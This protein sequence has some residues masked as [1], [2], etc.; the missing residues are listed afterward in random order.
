VRT[1][2][3]MSAQPPHELG[4]GAPLRGGSWP[5]TGAGE[6]RTTPRGRRRLLI[7]LIAGAVLIFL[8]VSLWLARFLSNENTERDTVVSLLRAQAAGD[9]AAMLER[10][11]GCR[12]L[13][14][15]AAQVERN[16]QGERAA[17]GVQILALSSPTAYSLTS[18]KGETRVAWRAGSGKPVVQCVVVERSGNGLT[19]LSIVLRRISAPIPN[20]SDC[21]PGSKPP[22]VQEPPE[23]M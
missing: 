6:E 16:A 11:E 21:P 10:L 20:E 8:L 7:G 22:I 13:P 1:L 15:C 17:G 14:S 3:L 5:A 12:K 2:G 9:A 4:E 18:A 19:G 23:G